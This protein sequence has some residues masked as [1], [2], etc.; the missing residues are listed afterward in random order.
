[1][2]PSEAKQVDSA[3]A[4]LWRL[5]G[6]VQGIGLR[7]AIARWAVQ[8]RLSGHVRNTTAGVELCLE[9]AAED[10]RAFETE[11]C[12]R[13]PVSA[14][15]A[16]IQRAP[17]R[18]LGRQEFMILNS[19]AESALAVPIPIDLAICSAC[20][21]DVGAVGNPRHAY[22]LISCAECG[23]RYSL[24]ESM[25]YDRHATTMR[26]FPLCASC[27]REYQSGEDRRFHAE[28]IA[29]PICG[30]RIWF[31][32]RDAQIHDTLDAISAAAAALSDGKIVALRGVGGYQLIVDATNEAAV[33]RL[34]LR[35]S[36]PS[37]PL[38]VMV[39]SLSNAQRLAHTC[40]VEISALLSP[41]NPIV[42]LSAKKRNGLASAVAGCLNTVGIML[43][44]TALHAMLLRT[45]GRPLVVTSANREGEPLVFDLQQAE[46]ELQEMAD[47]W[48]HHDR[49]I[50]SPIDDSVVRVMAGRRVTLRL[51]RGMAPLP[52]QLQ[53]IA[54]AIAIGG[55]QKVAIALCNGQQ[56]ALGPHVGDLESLAMRERF[57]RH[58]ALHSRI[59]DVEQATVVHDAHPDYLTTAWAEAGDSPRHPVQHHHAHVVS[60]MIEHGWLSRTVLGVAFDGA[61]YGP[62]G[63][64]WGGEFLRATATEFE[65]VGLLLPFGM[66]GGEMAV[67]EPWRMAVSL[68][69][70]AL[71]AE[72]ARRLQFAD[73]RPDDIV[74]VARLAES[75][76]LSTRSS[77][78][79]R[80]F[81]GA[82]ALALGIAR[83]GFEGQA[84]ML[85]ESACDAR[86]ADAYSFCVT[87]QEPFLA[88]WRPAIRELLRD[89]QSGVSPAILAMRFHRGVAEMIFQVCQR[90]A[91]LPVVMAGGV[92]QNRRLVELLHERFQWSTQ[93]L[94]LPGHIPPNDGGLAAGQ[95]AV[96][97]ARAHSEDAQRC[98]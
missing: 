19:S 76:R 83:V 54:S 62:D 95:L 89:R 71:G 57:E 49:H 21:D 84:A 93:L 40:A 6:L 10:L 70:A 52:L 91:E 9:G 32:T 45:A 80:L 61:G 1:M 41:P 42:V 24:I 20:L 77:S 2:S 3:V 53:P 72:S 78:A 81:D 90:F 18:A 43:P 33:V 36:R 59:Y 12:A 73:V 46:S 98:V 30:P 68:V 63:T 82:A 37:K 97:L 58:F 25:P 94:G 85:L 87:T 13:L 29:C 64:I 44:T 48:L 86:E 31:A 5:R 88:D 14:S 8:C 7:P 60:G 22:P 92:F 96:Y 50:H 26:H 16:E 38:A 67:R 35:K 27:M 23:P 56:S 15:V 34:R 47:A 66:P 55:Q 17:D 79:G 51:A 74:T 69:C 39:A 11:F 4:E 65:R 75:D 28:S